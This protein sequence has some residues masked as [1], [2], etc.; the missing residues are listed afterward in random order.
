MEKPNFGFWGNR[1]L[2]ILNIVREMLNDTKMNDSAKI[3]HIKMFL[4]IWL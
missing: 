2:K 1:Y 4:D 3:R